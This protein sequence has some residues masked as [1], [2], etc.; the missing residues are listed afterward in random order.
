MSLSTFPL[1]IGQNPT[2]CNGE[3][4][5]IQPK[6][7]DVTIPSTAET[8]QCS[9][10]L[11]F[12]LALQKLQSNQCCWNTAG[13]PT[14]YHRFVFC[15]TCNHGIWAA[16]NKHAVPGTEVLLFPVPPLKQKSIFFYRHFVLTVLVFNKRWY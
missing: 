14:W 8:H 12:P 5:A 9:A 4:S 3:D 10:S 7:E 2:K 6:P 11:R 13:E 16:R 15:S 1:E